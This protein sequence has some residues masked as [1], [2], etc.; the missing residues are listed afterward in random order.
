MPLTTFIEFADAAAKVIGPLTTLNPKADPY[1]WFCKNFNRKD[2][3]QW[4]GYNGPIFEESKAL[5]FGFNL[6]Y[7]ASWKRIF[8]KLCR[9]TD[10][11]SG[12]LQNLPGYEWHWWG[13]S[14]IIA[15]NPK[16]RVLS[17]PVPVEQINVNMWISD[18]EDILERRTG[19]SSSVAMRPQIH[20]VKKVA[21][22][23]RASAPGSLAA[24][25]QEIVNDLMPITLFL[26]K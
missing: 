17:K 6:E 8:P 4:A 3:I 26:E 20:I 22:S 19:W 24:R 13:R 1:P 14:A 15:R 10:T 18:L 2:D 11:F 25:I 16:Y 7:L 23:D 9:E 5:V 21:S 12:M